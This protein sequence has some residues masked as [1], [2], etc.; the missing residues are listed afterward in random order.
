MLKKIFIF[1][2]NE[3]DYLFLLNII[4]KFVENF[5]IFYENEI[6]SILNDKDFEFISKDTLIKG[7][8]H[9]LYS[10]TFK[11]YEGKERK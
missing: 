11:L 1:I 3:K 10:E 5:L 8:S 2:L 6:N 9:K 7:I 4:D